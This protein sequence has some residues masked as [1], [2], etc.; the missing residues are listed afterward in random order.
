MNFY[1]L[2]EYY[3]NSSN[4]YVLGFLEF[5]NSVFKISVNALFVMFIRYSFKVYV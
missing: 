1:S 5:I 3:N 4:K 2:D